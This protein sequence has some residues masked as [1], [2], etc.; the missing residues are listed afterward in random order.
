MKA[1]QIYYEPTVFTLLNNGNTIQANATTESN[2]IVVEGH[3]YTLNQFHFHTPSE[4][5]FNGQNHDMELHFVH[6][7]NNGKLAVFGVMIQKGKENKILASVWDELS[8]GETDE[9]HSE[10]YL[11]HL[12]ALLPQNKRSFHY[13]GSLTTPPCTENVKWIVFEQPIEMSKEQVQAFQ[14]IFSDNHRPVQ[15]LN[16]REIIKN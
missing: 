10:N 11:I 4:H 3:V 14:Q 8:E 6:S 5:Q 12:Q 15:P 9:I 2:R 1:N 7:D 13:N 16:N